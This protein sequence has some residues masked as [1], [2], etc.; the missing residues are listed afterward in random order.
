MV[1]LVAGLIDPQLSLFNK[2][3]LWFLVVLA[4]LFFLCY[5]IIA[6]KP[7]DADQLEDAKNDGS[8]FFEVV[9]LTAAGVAG[10]LSGTLSWTLKMLAKAPIDIVRRSG[11]TIWYRQAGVGSYLGNITAI[12]IPLVVVGI[13][14]AFIAMYFLL[15]IVILSW[16]LVVYKFI[17]NLI[18]I[19]G[20]RL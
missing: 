3:G 11:N 7:V 16:V 8:P 1:T 15:I 17:K 5:Y 10:G 20:P 9:G 12:L 14:L 6:F 4:I 19:K 13:V 2:N 18:Y